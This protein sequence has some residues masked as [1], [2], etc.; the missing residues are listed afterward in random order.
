ML[1]RERTT[2]EYKNVLVSCTEELERV[3]RIVS[4]MLFLA[5]ASNP[6][7][8]TSFES[9]ALEEE[10]EKV[11]ELFSLSA[12]DKRI[13][14]SVTGASARVLGDRLMIQRAISNL[15][16]NAL[17]HCPAGQTVSLHIE[18]EATEVALRV[19]NPGAGIE[20]QHLFDRFYRVDSSRSRSQGNTGLGL[21]I[22]RSIMSLHQ[23]VG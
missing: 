2:E 1:S 12:Q 19:S 4:D 15:L 17:R 18:Q 5:Q 10:A 16:S 13:S 6:A 21:A 20:A 8:L 7:A 11:A 14:L 9:V 3:A 23:G 22:V